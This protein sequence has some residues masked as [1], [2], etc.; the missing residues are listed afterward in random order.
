[1]NLKMTVERSSRR[2][3]FLLLEL[4]TKYILFTFLIMYIFFVTLEG[5][6]KSG[7]LYLLVCI[8]TPTDF[9]M[10]CTV[11]FLVMVV[12]VSLSLTRIAKLSILC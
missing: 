11:V 2:S 3:Y 1:M 5:L 8:P 7:I 12:L 10:F 9:I 4:I 6:S